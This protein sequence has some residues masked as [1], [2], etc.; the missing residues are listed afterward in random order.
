MPIVL[1]DGTFF[2]TLCAI[3]S[4]ARAAREPGNRRAC[5]AC[6][7]T[8]SPSICRR[9]PSSRRA[10]R[11]FWASARRR[12]SASSSSPCSATICAIRSPR[13]R[14]GTRLLLKE[15][16]SE[17]AVTILKMMQ[18]SVERMNGL[19]GDVLDF[20]RGRLGG[21]VRGGAAGGEFGSRPHPGRG[22]TQHRLSAG[23][24]RRADR[25]LRAQ[26]A[27]TGRG[28]ASCSRTCSATRS[29]T[30]ARDK[31]VRVRAA[32]E[33][34]FFE[35]SVSNAGDEISRRRAP[36]PLPALRAR[37]RQRQPAGP[38]AGPLHRLRDR[39]G[40]WRHAGGGIDGGGDPLH[41]PDEAVGP[42]AT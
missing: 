20:A 40:A 38:G 13:S 35:L 9:T 16:Q 12:S 11:A 5:S 23:R 36:A 4:Q 3:V 37:R 17:K 26:C 33:G 29:C 6:S 32:T 42:V 30:A 21:G 28:S 27:P 24:D 22:R 39:Q 19:I 25:R 1:H 18:Q 2:G 7:R 15:N 31:P 34:G 41:V 8:S 14:A 10:R